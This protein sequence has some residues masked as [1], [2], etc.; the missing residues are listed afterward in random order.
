MPIRPSLGVPAPG[1]TQEREAW[2]SASSTP[3]IYPSYVSAS[4]QR[5]LSPSRSHLRALWECSYVQQHGGAAVG[6]V[7]TSHSRAE[8]WP[9]GAAVHRLERRGKSAAPRSGPQTAHGVSPMARREL[10]FP[11]TAKFLIIIMIII[12][13]LTEFYVSGAGLCCCFGFFLIHIPSVSYNSTRY[14]LSHINVY[15]H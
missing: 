6:L 7:R 4:A 11:L 3:S 5:C 1:R 8:A 10:N 9:L 2:Q 12:A 15:M 13:K 14:A